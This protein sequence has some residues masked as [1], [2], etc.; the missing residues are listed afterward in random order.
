MESAPVSEAGDKSGE[1]AVAKPSKAARK[2]ATRR[3]KAAARVEKN[4]SH[5]SGVISETVITTSTSATL[6][7]AKKGSSSQPT[8]TNEEVGGASLTRFR[9]E[10]KASVIKKDES[11]YAGLPRGSKSLISAETLQRALIERFKIIRVTPRSCVA[12]AS[13]FVWIRF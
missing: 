5:K 11:I 4:Q 13:N 7:A 8:I 10:D 2:N 9:A 12:T 1:V 3:V 6:T